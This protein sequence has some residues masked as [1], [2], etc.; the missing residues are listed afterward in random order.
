M[1]MPGNSYTRAISAPLIPVIDAVKLPVFATSRR[2]LKVTFAIALCS[3]RAFG[4]LSEGAYIS[5]SNTVVSAH[6]TDVRTPIEGTISGLPL[7]EGNSV[8]AGQLLGSV[9]DPRSDHKHL[10]NLRILE[11]SALSTVAAL[12]AEQT[13]LQAQL[14]ALLSR[15]KL[16]ASAVSSRLQQQAVEAGRALSGLGT[17]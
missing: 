6:V 4:K 8:A 14:R 11:S 13:A 5:T 17:C 3:A 9:N 16:H 1:P 2:A 10:D 7:A 15:S 12:T